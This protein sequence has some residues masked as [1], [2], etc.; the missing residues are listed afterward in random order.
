MGLYLIKSALFV[1]LT[2]MAFA[3]GGDNSLMAQGD[4]AFQ[5]TPFQV[6]ISDL[7]EDAKIVLS[8]GMTFMLVGVGIFIVCLGVA[9]ILGVNNCT[10]NE[11]I[12]SVAML[13]VG[14]VASLLLCMGLFLVFTSRALVIFAYNFTRS[15]WVN[16]IVGVATLAVGVS[17]W[18]KKIELL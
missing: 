2:S 3:I 11:R 10:R 16:G 1:C 6:G 15:K 5:V 4:R 7:N 8:F 12:V 17:V 18:Y 13:A 9:V 14:S